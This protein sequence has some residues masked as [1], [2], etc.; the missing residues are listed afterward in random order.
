MVLL[1]A[2]VRAVVVC[3]DPCYLFYR[4]GQP[5]TMSSYRLAHCRKTVGSF[6][7]HE[8]DT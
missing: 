5:G 1:A 8:I 3:S 2:G 6:G 7:L 4:M